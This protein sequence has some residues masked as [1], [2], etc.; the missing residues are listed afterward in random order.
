MQHS[1][2]IGGSTARRRIEC[3]GSYQAELPI[4]DGGSSVYADEGTMLHSIMEMCLADGLP[5][6]EPEE[7]LGW[8][9]ANGQEFKQE[10]LHLAVS[11]LDAFEDLVSKFLGLRFRQ[12]IKVEILSVPGA[13]GTC[14]VLGVGSL[15]GKK[16]LLILDWKFGKGVVV[17]AKGN[18]QLAFYALGAMAHEKNFDEVMFAIVQPAREGGIDTWTTTPEW[19]LLYESLLVKAHENAQKKDAPRKVGA[20]CRWCKA[21][22]VC[23]KQNETV[24][25]ALSMEPEL[26]TSVELS[27]ALTLAS[28]LESWINDVRRRA[29]EEMERG[30]SLPGFELY[31][32]R[33][34]R[35][36]VDED[37]AVQHLL[38]HL[39]FDEVFSRKVVTP[40]QAEKALKAK[41]GS[42][43]ELCDIS[44]L[45]HKVSSGTVVKP[46]DPK[47]AVAN[48]SLGK[49]LGSALQKLKK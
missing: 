12:E 25:E 31:D 26:L 29:H 14:D 36:Y 37:A 43:H 9:H 32:K 28:Q 49:K 39:S 48:V 7:F 38:Q 8:K 19:L 42:K 47:K 17:D 27:H 18:Y 20:W 22:L 2:V 33:A 45:T 11:A 40:A 6:Y 21:R 34:N 23:S 44:S 24:N 1:N 30:V 5:A 35:K 10:H 46:L 4:A 16:V 13:F 41:Y 3:E 15:N